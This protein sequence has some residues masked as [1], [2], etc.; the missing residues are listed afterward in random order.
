M[1]EFLRFNKLKFF[2]FVTTVLL[3]IVLNL[4]ANIGISGANVVAIILIFE[5]FGL[6]LLV[7]SY[8]NI[9]ITSGPALDVFPVLWPNVFG[10]ILIIINI[11]VVLFIH[12]VV[13]SIIYKIYKKESFK[14]S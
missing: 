8:T 6:N 2:I 9:P 14:L 5:V 10:I 3:N 1:R 13:A 11:L 12:Y 7:G 4:F